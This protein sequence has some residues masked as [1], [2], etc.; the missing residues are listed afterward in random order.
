MLQ[1]YL[2]DQKLAGMSALV[3]HRGQVAYQTCL[4]MMDREAN[5]PVQFDTIFRIA[6]MTKP[7]TSIAAKLLYEQGAFNLNT[8]VSQ[9]IPAFKTEESL[10]RAIHLRP[11]PLP[12]Q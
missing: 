8:P 7:V 4:G 10:S 2:A 9:F 11:Q 5:K 12:N 1:T 3:S 6:S